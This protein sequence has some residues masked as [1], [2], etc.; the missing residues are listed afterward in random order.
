[1]KKIAII[2]FSAI[3]FATLATAL[4]GPAFASDPNIIKLKELQFDISETLK[5]N[6]T[7]TGDNKKEQQSQTYFG[8]GKNPIIEFIIRIINFALTLMGSIAIII[9]IIGGFQMMFSQGNQQKL[10]E[11]KDVVKYAVIGIIV[12]LLS[13]VIIITI[14]SIFT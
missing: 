7:G 6:P 11:A 12:A 9:L 5:L 10:D 14:Q 13:Y 8:E 1:M 4:N 2:L 3:M